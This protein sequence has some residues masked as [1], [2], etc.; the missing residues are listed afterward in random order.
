MERRSHRRKEGHLNNHR[1]ITSAI[2]SIGISIRIHPPGFLF[3]LL[4][5]LVP[6][7]I[8]IWNV[9]YFYWPFQ[10]GTSFVDH[11]RYLCLVFVMR[12][13]LFIA[14]LWS[15]ERKGLASW[16][17]FVMFIVILLLSHLLPWDR[18][19]T[20]SYRFL[21]IAVFLTFD[22]LC[23]YVE[24]SIK[25]NIVRIFR[26]YGLPPWTT[27]PPTKISGS[28]YILYTMRMLFNC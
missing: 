16:L 17:L 13:R 5:I 22:P 20:W 3:D 9:K 14:A 26:Q 15:S 21:I 25:K 11:L 19:G 1:W 23:K 27:S 2:V 7:V 10:G 24:E 12:S 8:R 18:C 4:E 6:L 28:D